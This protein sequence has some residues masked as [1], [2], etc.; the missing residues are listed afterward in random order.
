MMTTNFYEVFNSVLKGTRNLPIIACVQTTF[1]RVND[2]FMLRR[3]ATDARLFDGALYPS[4]PS[5]IA[6]KLTALGVRV[7][8]HAVRYSTSNRESWR[9]RQDS[10]AFTRIAEVI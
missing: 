2:Y 10:L 8:T 4:L 9:S 1:Y 7:N 3:K 5:N 6:T